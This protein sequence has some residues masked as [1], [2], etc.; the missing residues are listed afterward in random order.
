MPRSAGVPFTRAVKRTESVRPRV[1]TR[2][3]T[4]T[5]TS[6]VEGGRPPIVGVLSGSV[7]GRMRGASRSPQPLSNGITAAMAANRNHRITS[8]SQ[9]YRNTPLR[10]DRHVGHAHRGQIEGAVHLH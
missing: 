2:G 4:V 9:T 1:M 8:V 10:S 3:S 7:P 6:A 5:Q